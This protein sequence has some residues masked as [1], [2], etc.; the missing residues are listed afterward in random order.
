[1]LSGSIARRY[2]RALFAIGEEQGTLV[3]LVREV[4]R[5]AETWEGSAELRTNVTSPMVK[6]EARRAMWG[7]V[8]QKLAVSR[9]TR[10]FL[11]MLLDRNR[12]PYLPS[13]AR[14]LSEMGD[15]KENRLRAEVASAKPVAADVVARLRGVLERQTG[16]TVVLTTRQDPALIGGMVTKVG[17]LLY[18]GSLKTQLERMKESMLGR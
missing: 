5:A 16:K 2:A 10:S 4:Q 8:A 7:A 18:D 1:M 11:D 3:A 6:E 15:R 14:E 9:I 17:N 12:L 13:I